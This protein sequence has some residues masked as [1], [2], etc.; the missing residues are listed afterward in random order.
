MIVI[1]TREYNT[2]IENSSNG[3]D[4]CIDKFTNDFKTGFIGKF[5]PVSSVHV[6]S[7]FCCDITLICVLLVPVYRGILKRSDVRKIKSFSR[8]LLPFSYLPIIHGLK[9]IA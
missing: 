6:C 4:V 3:Q 5:H 7:V 2:H 1:Q 8:N 9:K